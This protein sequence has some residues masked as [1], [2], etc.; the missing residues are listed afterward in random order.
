MGYLKNLCVKKV[1]FVRKGANKKEFFL[2]KSAD[3]GEEKSSSDD[4]KKKKEEDVINNDGNSNSGGTTVRPEIRTK[5][6]GILKAERNIEK[7][8]ALLKADTAIAVKDEELGEISEFLAMIPPLPADNTEALKKAEADLAAAEVEKKALGERLTKVEQAR[9]RDEI[10]KWVTEECPYLNVKVDDAVDRIVQAETAG[11]AVAK[12]LKEAFKGTSDTLRDSKLF[13][14]Q[15]QDNREED[16]IGGNILSDVVKKVN[17]IK[18]SDGLKGSEAVI[19]AVKSVGGRRYEQ[20][21]TEFN[22]RAK[23]A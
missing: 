7:V 1:S 17:E 3:F 2:A 9:H 23:Q 5:L 10:K 8:V 13:K 11:E 19:E 14:D 18:K 4:S 6:A 12:M 16:T 21:R 22:K 20:Y 15:G